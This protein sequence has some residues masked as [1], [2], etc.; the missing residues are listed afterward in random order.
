MK[1]KNMSIQNTQDSKNQLPNSYQ[2][3]QFIV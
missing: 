2:D 1:I 3:F